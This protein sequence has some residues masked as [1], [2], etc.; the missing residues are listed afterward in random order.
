[1]PVTLAVQFKVLPFQQD[2]KVL[3]LLQFDQEDPFARGVQN[4]RRHI[5]N[6]AGMRLD[7]VEQATHRVDVLAHYQRLEL[8]QN[9]ILLQAEI[10]LTPIDYDPRLRLTV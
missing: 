10:N 7:S 3:R 8:I 5:D 2:R 4:T 6:V 1:M 9:H